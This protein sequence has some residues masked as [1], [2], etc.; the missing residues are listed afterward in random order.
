MTAPLASMTGF[1]RGEGAADGGAWTWEL[2][3]VNGRGLDLRLRLPPG[4]DAL[5][6]SL[7]EIAGKLLRRGSVTASL[8]VKRSEQPRLV[9][10][11][12]ALDQAVCLAMELHR[13]IPGS[14]IPRA[15]TLLCLPGILRSP[16]VEPERPEEAITAAIR[17]GFAQALD[18]LVANRRAEGARLAGLMTS[19]LGEIAGLRDAA[20]AE[21]ADQPAAQRA[22]LMENLQLLLREA[23][24]LPEE[25]IAQ[26]VALLAARSDVREELDRLESHIH[27]AHALLAE[28][29]GIGRRFDFLVQE[30]NREANTLCS[31]SASARAHHDRAKA[32]GRDR[33]ASRAGAEH[34]MKLMRRGLCLVV[35]APSGAGKTSVVQALLGLEPEL[36]LSVSVTTRASRPGEREGVDYFFRDQAQFERLAASGDL[37]EWAT[38]FGRSYGTP[39]EPVEA[40]LGAGRD[41]VFD[42]DWQGHAQLRAKMPDDVIGVFLLPPSL[43]A[44]ERRLRARGSDSPEEIA[45]RMRAARDEVSH[46]TE[47]DHL[48]VNA[49]LEETVRSVRAVLHAARLATPRQTGAAELAAELIGG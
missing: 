14:P 32:Q 3:S 12:A 2:R 5:E 19:L 43:P 10:D 24:T 31:K 22:R 6:P 39:R 7:R 44:L 48:V 11:L 13:R 35:A 30:F 40:A 23:P 34:R 9:P 1:A 29:A 42:I 21:A 28:G 16:A 15:E 47:F 18:Q 4:Y 38:V 36:T 41:V 8:S 37:L 49:S 45:H 33:A 46:W 26:E 25:R 17:S 20:A 27:A